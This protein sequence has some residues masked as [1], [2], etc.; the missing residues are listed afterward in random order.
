MRKDAS[1]RVK[2][3]N[4]AAGAPTV[5][6]ESEAPAVCR[7]IQGELRFGAEAAHHLVT[8]NRQ[9]TQQRAVEGKVPQDDR[10]GDAKVRIGIGVIPNVVIVFEI[11]SFAVIASVPAGHRHGRGGYTRRLVSAEQRHIDGRGAWIRDRACIQTAER[12][13]F[14]G[15]NGLGISNVDCAA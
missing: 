12:Q 9:H 11:G 10:R 15:N 2:G 14:T 6:Y 8:G 3:E 1:R 7:A 13:Y 4:W 5:A